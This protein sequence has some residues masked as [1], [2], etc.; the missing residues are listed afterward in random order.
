LP[1]FDPVPRPSRRLSFPSMTLSLAPSLAPVQRPLL[2]PLVLFIRPC[3]VS[4]Q[5]P[6]PR[7]SPSR[8]PLPVRPLPSPLY[9]ANGL[10]PVSPPL[11]SEPCSPSSPRHPSP[12]SI[13]PSPSLAPVIRPLPRPPSLPESRIPRPEPPTPSPPKFSVSRPYP[14]PPISLP[15]PPSLFCWH[16]LPFTLYSA[17]SIVRVVVSS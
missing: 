4:R 12:P 11:R 6:S 15:S 3:A 16:C 5:W 13:A 2:T 1:V 17:A 8:S 10:R 7:L 9:L 14:S